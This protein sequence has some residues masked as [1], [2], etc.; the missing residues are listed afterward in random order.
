MR[1]YTTRQTIIANSPY[2]IM[3]LIGAA[4]IAFG[5]GFTRWTL[6]GTSVYLFYGIAGAILDHDFC[7]SLLCIL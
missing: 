2:I 1:H 4:T 5:F 6:L 7:L 3:I